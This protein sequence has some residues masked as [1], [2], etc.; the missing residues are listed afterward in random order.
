MLGR[1]ED[2]DI[3]VDSPA[4]SRRHA[5]I[6]YDSNRYFIEDLK[7]RNGT[8]VNG[9]P[10]RQRT[11]LRH[12]DH[13]EI[14]TLPFTFQLENSL[15]DASASWSV[16][17]RIISLSQTGSDYGDSV[18]RQIVTTG[19]HIS[20]D[21]LGADPIRE[22]QLIGKLPV[23][24]S[25]GWPVTSNA[26]QKLNHALRLM[27]SLRQTV[28][29]ND[30]I[31]NAMQVLFD[32]FPSAER[33]AI[34]LHDPAK[35]GIH[36]AAAASRFPDEEVEICLPVVRSAMSNSEA[37]LY[38]DHWK[39]ADASNP[40]LGNAT[41]RS[42]LAGPLIGLAGLN[43]GAIQLDTTDQTRPLSKED[44][45]L[46]VILN[47]V[48]SFTLDQVIFAETEVQRA[49]L[50]RSTADASRLRSNLAPSASPE[51]P[52][53]RLAH[54]LIATPDIAAD[55]IDYI[56]LPDGR[57]VC[58]VIDV[59]GR[60]LEAAGLMAL[61]ARL[62]VGA[63]TESGSAAQ[64]LR[65]AETAL[66]ERMDDVPMVISVAM[67]IVNADQSSVTAAI[68]GHCPLILVHRDDIR[69]VNNPQ[70][71]G[72]PLG[73]VRESYVE[74]EIPLYDND[75]LMLFTDGI[76]K[77]CSPEG[78]SLT[79]GEMLEI[80]EDAASGHRTAFESHVSNRLREFRGD[81]PL[82]DDVAFVLINRTP[83]A[84]T[85]DNLSQFGADSEAADL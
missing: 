63:V 30:V 60:G 13:V 44:L 11:V 64:A 49:L 84:G 10:V 14:S 80:V 52:G 21:Q 53:Y 35:P 6:I 58:I 7:S 76:T 85:V 17:P 68:A 71:T 5:Q 39:G 62:L 28:H 37:M 61:L 65:D 4:V 79:R 16:K 2:C 3:V 8:T 19:D 1:H 47:H 38:V 43:I 20:R 46:L 51:L 24:D 34:V 23:S 77:L 83:A 70:I 45:E 33:M 25:S 55:L 15:S 78:N 56:R 36:V 81:A 31:S 26:A 41:V 48:M 40:E 57:V 75:V 74:A 67:L 50:E 18:R 32:V 42:I 22:G 69:D 82:I 72:P 9:R 12:G 27:H 66:T 59:P 73:S 54:E 29:H